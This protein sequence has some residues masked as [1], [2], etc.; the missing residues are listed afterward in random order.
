MRRGMRGGGRRGKK[1]ALHLGW[2]RIFLCL[3]ISDPLFRFAVRSTDLLCIAREAVCLL[4]RGTSC[5]EKIGIRRDTTRRSPE[6]G[7]VYP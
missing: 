6:G 7:G 1:I 5:F 2:H 4:L 3:F